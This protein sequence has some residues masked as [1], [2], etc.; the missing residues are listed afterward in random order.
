MPKITYTA[1][2]K[3]RFPMQLRFSDQTAL[4]SLN[5][6]FPICSLSG[7]LG[8]GEGRTGSHGLWTGCHVPLDLGSVITLAFHLADAHPLTPCWLQWS[9]HAQQRSPSQAMTLISLLMSVYFLPGSI[10]KPL[11]SHYLSLCFIKTLRGIY[12][13]IISSIL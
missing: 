6:T 10:L 2:R 1:N 9:G 12:S 5:L 13:S 7:L 8:G 4:F 11:H 3:V